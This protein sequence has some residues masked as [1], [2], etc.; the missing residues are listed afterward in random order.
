MPLADRGAVVGHGRDSSR[1]LATET[2]TGTGGMA[3]EV[4]CSGLAELSLGMQV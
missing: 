3:G 2:G 4:K 1:H